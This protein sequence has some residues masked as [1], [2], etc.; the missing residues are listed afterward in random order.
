MS[1][2]P[3]AHVAVDVNCVTL[4]I[5]ETSNLRV[6]LEIAALQSRQQ[7]LHRELA[8]TQHDELGSGG[9]ILCYV[10]TGL[11]TP[12]DRTPARLSCHSQN[13]NDIAA[14]HEVGVHAKNRGPFGSKI[15]EQ[16]IACGECCV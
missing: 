2:T 5:G 15:A 7:L 9:E 10:G 13:L 1:V 11:G 8:F 4:K 3:S 14:S 16:H 12:Y 6:R